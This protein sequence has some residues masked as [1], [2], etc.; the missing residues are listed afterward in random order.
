VY[1]GS[2]VTSLRSDGSRW[3]VWLDDSRVH[4]WDDDDGGSGVE[5]GFEAETVAVSSKAIFLSGRGNAESGPRKVEI[6][7]F[8][9]EAGPN[10]RITKTAEAP[11][12]GAS[13]GADIYF[14][15]QE[16]LFKALLDGGPAP[17]GRLPH[18]TVTNYENETKFIPD[19]LLIDDTN[20]VFSALVVTNQALAVARAVSRGN[21]CNTCPH[22]RPITMGDP[23]TLAL[24]KGVVYRG[25]GGVL[26]SFPFVQLLAPE[27][28]VDAQVVR[29]LGGSPQ[30]LVVDDGDAFFVTGGAIKR[31]KLSRAP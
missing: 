25:V 22:V 21:C 23:H 18:C 9:Q 13:F 27:G 30:Y 17:P 29:D 11:I 20:G 3:V 7:P 19:Q 10:G 2:S 4:L 15:T 26:E 16:F 8:G 24:R 1:T 14:S 5:T 6:V 28:G 31:L 12:Q